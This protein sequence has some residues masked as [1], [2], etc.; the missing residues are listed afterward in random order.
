MLSSYI[1]I[2]C[3]HVN[4]RDSFF[5]LLAE[6][7]LVTNWVLQTALDIATTRDLWTVAFKPPRRRSVHVD[8]YLKDK[9][10]LLSSN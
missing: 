6:G 4:Y 5:I 1:S 10:K 7:Q 8:I 3:L 9:R 2:L